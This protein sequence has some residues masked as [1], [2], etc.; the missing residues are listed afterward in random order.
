[1]NTSVTVMK[2][3]QLMLFAEMYRYVLCGQIVQFLMVT[4][5]GMYSNQQIVKV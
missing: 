1:M 5:G 4:T 3:S 2:I